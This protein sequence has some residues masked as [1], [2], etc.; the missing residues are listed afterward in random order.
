MKHLR[1]EYGD[2]A[3]TLDWLYAAWD[4][5][6]RAAD[7]YGYNDAVLTQTSGIAWKA[8]ETARNDARD[9]MSGQSSLSAAQTPTA[10]EI[11]RP[12]GKYRVAVGDADGLEFDS[13]FFD[14]HDAGFA[15][16]MAD[17]EDLRQTQ[18][19]ASYRRGY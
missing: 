14:A 8:Y 2:A 17:A 4:A 19:D 5:A 9:A 7:A 11:S 16:Q 13:A 15:E 10:G 12:A 1:S 6:D 18:D 3:P